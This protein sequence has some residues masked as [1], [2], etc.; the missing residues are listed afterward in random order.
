MNLAVNTDG[1]ALDPGSD[2]GPL[3]APVSRALRRSLT[4]LVYAVGPAALALAILSASFARAPFL[5]DFDGGLSIRRE[6]RS[7]TDSLP[8]APITCSTGRR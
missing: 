2:P 1:V 6:L 5:S 7:S 8:I 4:V 3:R